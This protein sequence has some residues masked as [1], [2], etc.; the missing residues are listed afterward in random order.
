MDPNEN[1]GSLWIEASLHIVL[2]EVSQAE[3][4]QQTNPPFVIIKFL[5][6]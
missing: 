2:K 5:R 3:E 1:T 4:S 6:K